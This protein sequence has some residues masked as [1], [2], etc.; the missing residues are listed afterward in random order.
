[1]TRS[2][3]LRRVGLLVLAVN[4][5]LFAL[6]GAVWSATGSLAV[7]SEAV[8]SLADAVYSVVILAGLYLT[9]QPPDFE[10]PHGHERIEP[11]VALAVAVGIAAAGAAA[12]L[13]ALGTLRAGSI[14]TPGTLAA[15][16]LASGAVVKYA[17]YRYCL[18]VAGTHGS[19]ALRATAADNRADVLTAGAALAG[20][21]GATAGSP[22][23]DPLAG[24]VVAV[25]ILRTG[26][27]IARDNLGYLLGAAPDEERRAVIV[28]RALSHPDVEAVHDVVAHHVGPEVDVS[29][30]VEVDGDLSIAEAHGIETDVMEAIRRFDDI[31]DVYV[32]LDPRGAGEWKVGDDGRIVEDDEPDSRER[33]VGRGRS[34]SSDGT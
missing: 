28:D 14:T 6:K 2:T 24:A 30:H 11:F 23:L 22:L 13:N 10:H 25:G 20:V 7:G 15:A 31:D 8:N 12:L 5:A 9:T 3:A 18:R 29:L 33:G 16:V 26:I 17:L 19:P 1:M 34:P 4:A 27:G 21:L 32:H